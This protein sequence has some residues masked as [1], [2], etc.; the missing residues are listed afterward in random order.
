[1][2]TASP[3]VR[4]SLSARPG[5]LLTNTSDEFMRN[6]LIVGAG[7]AL[8]GGLV[9]LLYSLYRN[10]KLKKSGMP[11]YESDVEASLTGLIAGVAIAVI[12]IL[13]YR[14]GLHLKDVKRAYTAVPGTVVSA[15]RPT[16][17]A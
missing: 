5:Y 13:I 11:A 4:S 16:L 8:A 15:S 1:M 12:A 17:V 2:A 3:T 6:E 14:W 9:G 7:S 10:N